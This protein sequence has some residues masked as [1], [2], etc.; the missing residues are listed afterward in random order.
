MKPKTNKHGQVLCYH[1]DRANIDCRCCWISEDDEQLPLLQDEA[2]RLAYGTSLSPPAPAP[3]PSPLSSPASPVMSPHSSPSKLSPRA[4]SVFG[5]ETS[6]QPMGC[7]V[8]LLEPM[9]SFVPGL[10]RSRAIAGGWLREVTVITRRILQRASVNSNRK[11]PPR[12]DGGASLRVSWER[13]H[14]RGTWQAAIHDPA[15]LRLAAVDRLSAMLM[16]MLM[17]MMVTM[18][19][20][21]CRSKA[22]NGTIHSHSS[23]PARLA[24]ASFRSLDDAAAGCDGR[25]GAALRR[26]AF[27]SKLA[28]CCCPTNG[29]STIFC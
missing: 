5:A 21:P 18:I 28:A 23:G 9:L 26:F 16:L 19:L 13:A 25:T 22:G 24:R 14:I 6:G 15:G 29:L 7:W 8:R 10:L 2:G 11:K 17:T 20:L 27:H 1:L 3:P 12:T 4:P